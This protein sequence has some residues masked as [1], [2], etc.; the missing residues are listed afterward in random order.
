MAQ[1]EIQSLVEFV[2]QN[3]ENTFNQ[4]LMGICTQLQV[5]VEEEEKR[6]Q[7]LSFDSTTTAD[8]AYHSP[9]LKIIPRDLGEVIQLNIPTI[10]GKIESTGQLGEMVQ[11]TIAAPT[12]QTADTDIH[13]HLQSLEDPSSSVQANVVGKGAGV[14]RFTYTPRVR[15]VVGTDS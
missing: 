3:V 8:L 15:G 14:Y 10:L 7:R 6:H 11:V 12:A 2:E 4:D 9:S 1:T 13:A 5:K